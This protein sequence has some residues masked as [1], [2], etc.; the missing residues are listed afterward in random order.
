MSM[1]ESEVRK[2]KECIQEFVQDQEDAIRQHRQAASDA[3][4][5]WNRFVKYEMR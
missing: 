2:Y 3:I 5:D 1:Y 4:D